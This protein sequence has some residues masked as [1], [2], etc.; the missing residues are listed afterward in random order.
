MKMPP[1]LYYI[2]CLFEKVYDT[3]FIKIDQRIQILQ[4]KRDQNF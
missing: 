3:S 4:L 2:R 1:V